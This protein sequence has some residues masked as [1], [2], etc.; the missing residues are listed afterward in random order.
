MRPKHKATLLSTL[1]DAKA[2]LCGRVSGTK[3]PAGGRMRTIIRHMMQQQLVRI[4]SIRG[5]V[6]DG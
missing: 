2:V 1:W 3:G 6:D 5:G 4:A